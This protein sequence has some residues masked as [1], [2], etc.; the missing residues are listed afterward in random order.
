MAGVISWTPAITPR[1]ARTDMEAGV[2]ASVRPGDDFFTYANGAWLK[3][4]TIPVDKERW[5][6]RSE[7]EDVTR[8]QVVDL[9]DAASDAHVGS[10]ARKVADFRAAYLNEAAIEAAGIAP[11]QP[12][13]KR[14]DSLHD[15]TALTRLLGA[16]LRADVDPMN[17][18]VYDSAHVLGLAVEAGLHGEK[19]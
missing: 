17:W 4:T 6:A 12:W 14:I 2:D 7:I 15:K 8:Q 10:E 18:G 13:L 1:G 16:M 19:I 9:L 5:N 3:R 11:L